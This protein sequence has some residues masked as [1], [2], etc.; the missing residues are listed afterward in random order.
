MA[1]GFGWPKVFGWPFFVQ[2]QL[3]LGQPKSLSISLKISISFFNSITYAGIAY[4]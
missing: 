1:R 2:L 4:I 3:L